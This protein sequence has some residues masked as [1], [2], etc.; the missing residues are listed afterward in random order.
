MLLVQLRDHVERVT[1]RFVG[2]AFRIGQ[3]KHGILA[4]TEYRALVNRG[5]EARAVDA[6]PRL[7]RPVG[8]HYVPGE[9]LILRSETVRA[10]RAETRP[11]RELRAGVPQVHARG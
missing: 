1:L 8:H 7:H 2:D 5:K 10:P 11:A 9:I 4:T 6:R 3:V